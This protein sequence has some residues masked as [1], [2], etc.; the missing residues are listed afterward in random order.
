MNIIERPIIVTLFVGNHYMVNSFR[1]LLYFCRKKKK[2]LFPFYRY[3]EA[4]RGWITTKLA[5]RMPRKNLSFIRVCM[6]PSITIPCYLQRLTTTPLLPMPHVY[7]SR[8]QLRRLYC[9]N[10]AFWLHF[11]VVFKT[12]NKGPLLP[13]HS[14]LWYLALFHQNQTGETT[15]QAHSWQWIS[16]LITTFL[17]V[18]QGPLIAKR[19]IF[20]LW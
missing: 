7:L 13:L 4:Q 18:S 17:S 1:V 3:A 8:K 15:K 5:L 20:L 19:L 16:W 6:L 12:L 11:L 10:L 14:R 2:L 9:R